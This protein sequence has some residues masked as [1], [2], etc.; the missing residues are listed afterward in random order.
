M[1]SSID[2]VSIV[3]TF[4]ISNLGDVISLVVGVLDQRPCHE[5]VGSSPA[6]P[7]A[8]GRHVATVAPWASCSLHPGPG[9]PQPSILSGLVNEYR[10]WLGRFKTGV[11]NASV[12][13]SRSALSTM[14]A[15]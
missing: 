13:N 3:F 14:T 6:V 15:P 11:C 5:V 10:L 1:S 4:N 12:V 9:L 8:A 7:L 2:S